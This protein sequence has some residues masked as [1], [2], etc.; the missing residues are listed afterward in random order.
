LTLT[1]PFTGTAAFRPDLDAVEA[2]IKSLRGR[3]MLAGDIVLAA[4][5][6]VALRDRP[7]NLD[8][9]TA[10]VDELA[11]LIRDDRSGGTP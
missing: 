2:A 6:T 10:R 11:F 5:C 8:E 1:D 4:Y 9:T 7:R 3:A